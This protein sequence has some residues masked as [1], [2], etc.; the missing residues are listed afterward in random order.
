M[1]NSILNSS[2]DKRQASGCA[3]P[4]DNYVD[5]ALTSGEK[6][7]AQANGWLIAGGVT[8]KLG[9]VVALQ[10]QN[11]LGNQAVGTANGFGIFTNVPVK[12]GDEITVYYN[13]F[14]PN[15]FRFIY[16]EGEI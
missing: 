14:T 8:T 11:S 3:M 15:R 1:F 13:A 12:K 9:G 10:N 5:L 7:I 2:V 6:Y 4:S 16:A